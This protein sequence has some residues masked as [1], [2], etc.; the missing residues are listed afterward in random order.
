MLFLV[1]SGWGLTKLMKMNFLGI[2]DDVIQ[3]Q[4]KKERIVKT[5]LCR[6]K[7]VWVLASLHGYVGWKF[8]RKL[9][10]PTFFLGGEVRPLDTLGQTC[11]WRPMLKCQNFVIVYILCNDSKS[12]QPWIDS[13]YHINIIYLIHY[14]ICM[15]TSHIASG[16][17]IH[18]ASL[19]WC[20]AKGW[21]SLQP[22]YRRQL[23]G[24][25]SESTGCCLVNDSRKGQM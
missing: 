1:C 9:G 18:P 4:T 10:L 6:R 16:V 12:M 3:T 11:P 24:L 23:C 13:I 20:F 8:S 21:P 17:S 19:A 14:I 5:F 7:R 25:V 15:D 22:N 2:E